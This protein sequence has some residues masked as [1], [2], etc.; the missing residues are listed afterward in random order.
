MEIKFFNQTG[1][2]V[3][4]LKISLTTAALLLMQKTIFY[5]LV[6]MHLD[7]TKALHFKNDG[8]DRIWTFFDSKSPIVLSNISNSFREVK[9]INNRRKWQ[10]PPLV[11]GAEVHVN[12][13][14]EIESNNEDSEN[15]VSGEDLVLDQ[16]YVNSKK[17]AIMLHHPFLLYM[18]YK[19]YRDGHLTLFI[20]ETFL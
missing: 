14:S 12:F 1:H 17:Q 19:R 18:T 20:V 3:Q 9:N 5:P 4:N 7:R 15:E 13:Y 11:V 10:A 6:R 16:N 8:L 2:E